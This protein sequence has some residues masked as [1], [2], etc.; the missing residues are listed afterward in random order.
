MAPPIRWNQKEV[1][2][3]SFKANLM[4]FATLLA[5]AVWF[6]ALAPTPTPL[7]IA[8]LPPR[9]A[10]PVPVPS[11]TPAQ[12]SLTSD[13]AS[14]IDQIAIDTLRGQAVA[15]ISLAVVRDGRVVYSRGYGFSSI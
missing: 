11:A 10:S 6:G 2:F 7:P 13:Q 3:V 1:R 8:T 12:P 9:S 5:A 4:I 14:K 15:G